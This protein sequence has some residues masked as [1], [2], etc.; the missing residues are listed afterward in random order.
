V[1]PEVGSGSV[2]EERN[3]GD[4]ET[5][6]NG[7]EQVDEDTLKVNSFP[8]LHYNGILNLNKSEM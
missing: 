2:V 7:Q 5:Q 4:W 3:D 1:V 6:Q 8:L